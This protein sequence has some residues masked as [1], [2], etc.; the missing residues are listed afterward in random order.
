MKPLSIVKLA[1]LLFLISF[2][3]S[4]K[5]SVVEDIRMWHAPERS[6]FVFDIDTKPDYKVYTLKSPDRLVVDLERSVLGR[7]MPLPEKLG[8][9]VGKMRSG[10]PKPDT[11]RVVFEIA[12][13]IRYELQLLKPF[14]RYQYR[15]VIDFYD[16]DHV[17]EPASV[18]ASLAVPRQKRERTGDILI[19]ID[20]G[21]GGEDPGAVGKRSY[22]KTIV[23]SVAKKLKNMLN[24][25]PGLRAELTRTGDYYISLRRRI[26]MA[27][28]INADLFVS[29][30]ADGHHNTKAQGASVYALS[31]RGATSETA[32]W[33]ADKENSADLAG[34]VSISDKDDLLA[35][36]LLDL[37]MT[38][39]VSESISFGR[40]VLD[41]LKKIGKVHSKRVE[42][43]GFAVL[44]SPD[45][46]SILVETAYITN[47]KEEKLLGTKSHQTKLATA[48]TNG[49]KRYLRKN[50]G[51]YAYQY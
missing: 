13:P 29:V 24:K 42:Q 5:S 22:E 26:I 14:D 50:Q 3:V 1:L 15:L 11:L 12:K 23:L 45:I 17:E 4:A 30:H 51:I 44:K 34:G 19:V 10:N 33:L 21:H 7:P 38:K 37:S 16:Q 35:E 41:E 48:I 49:I 28:N 2:S 20:A 8:P 27:R 9:Y 25:E 36:V 32:R 18:S 43:A 31:Q 6:R 39:T 46:P 40:E 47:P